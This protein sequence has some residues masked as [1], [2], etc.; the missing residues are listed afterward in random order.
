M[1]LTNIAT[2]FTKTM[3]RTGL[4]LKKYSPQIMM[5]SG[6]IGIGTAFVLAIKETRKVDP[7][8][9]EHNEKR[10]ALAD[11]TVSGDLVEKE[12]KKETTKLYL[13]TSGELVKLYAPSVSLAVISVGL[14]CGSNYILNKRNIAILG[15]FKASEEAFKQYRQ[16]VLE[17]LGEEKDQQ[18]RYGIKEQKIVEVTTDENGDEKMAEKSVQAVDPNTISQYARFF[19]A[20]SREWCKTPEYN[21][22]FLQGQQNK[23]NDLLRTRG[24]VF[25]NEVYD[26]LDIPRS[27]AGQIVGWV[28]NKE[29]GDNFIDFG[30]FDLNNERKRAFVNGDEAN[31]LLDFNVDGVIYD[32]I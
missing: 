4:V 15:A 23:F 14:M 21:L 12:L 5:V 13:H 18:Y 20:A 32:L 25:L 6:V 31:I 16:R 17:E 24:H 19:D 11:P 3:G 7:I 29:D 27:Q 9:K 2:T 30:I 8:L 1:K 22:M 28:Y 26:A 10:L